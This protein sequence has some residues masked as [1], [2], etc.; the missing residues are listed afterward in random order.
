MIISHNNN[1]GV[2]SIT[3]GKDIYQ[4][5]M[6]IYK[7]DIKLRRRERKLKRLA[8]ELIRVLENF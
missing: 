5:N 4:R 6:Y 1:C 7:F 8:E 2:Q 3:V